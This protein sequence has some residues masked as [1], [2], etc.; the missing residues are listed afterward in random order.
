ME[1][2]RCQQRH[3]SSGITNNVIVSD[4][5]A[6]A[7]YPDKK[8]IGEMPH[9]EKCYFEV[10]SFYQIPDIAHDKTRWLAILNATIST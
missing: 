6:H 2:G 5:D 7:S 8:T 10:V 9:S 4:I 3:L 1:V